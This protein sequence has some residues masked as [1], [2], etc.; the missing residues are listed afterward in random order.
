MEKIIFQCET[1]TPMFLAGADGKTPELRP[2]SIKAALRFW[3]RAMNGHLSLAELKE[4][5][6]GIFG[7]SG[8]H[9]GRSKLSIRVKNLKGQ[10]VSSKFPNHMIRAFSKGKTFNIN[11]LEYLAYGT[12]EYKKGIGQVFIREYFQV[13][14]KFEIEI[15]F[16]NSLR[17]LIDLNEILGLI[18]QVGGLGAKSRNGF[19][20]FIVKDLQFNIVNLL[21]KHKKDQIANYLAFNKDTRL[22]KLNSDYKSWDECLANLGKIYKS[23]R[24]N[25][26][27]RH[28]FEK[29]QFIASPILQNKRQVSLLDRH[30]K[31]YFFVLNKNSRGGFE[32][33]I[34]F[35]PYN[36]LKG[37]ENPPKSQKK[38]QDDFLRYTSEFNQRLK[39]KMGV[40]L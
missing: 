29:R 9:E 13:G 15:N 17:Q 40:I 3:W 12:Q 37:F 32:G 21:Q 38:L 14:T 11:I 22:Y 10:V 8:E 16:A 20:R 35:I 31:P 27:P 1:I 24:E 7:G 34:L 5:E 6:A 36:Y 19:G 18:S 33:K 26:E 39:E 30:T 4:K 25:L 23:S 2:P 28:K